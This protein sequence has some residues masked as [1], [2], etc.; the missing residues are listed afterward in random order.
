MRKA[1]HPAAAFALLGVG[2]GALVCF[3]TEL[4]YIRDAFEGAAAR[5]NTIFKFYYQVWLIWGTLAGYALWW[6]IAGRRTEDGRTD[7]QAQSVVGGRWSVVDRV[8]S[9]ACVALTA[10]LFVGALVYPWLT[11]G[12]ALREQP[13]IGL[14][15]KTP[16]Q[17]SAGGAAGIAWLRANTNGAEIVLESVGGDY[18][19]PPGGPGGAG[20]SAST[21]LATVLGWPG[22]ED[23]WRGGDPKAQAQIAPR[24][25]DVET[26]Y[27]STDVEQVRGLLDK[28]N[29]AFVYIGE[30]ER[31]RYGQT[32]LDKF[33]QLGDKVFAQD[34]VAIYK[35][36]QP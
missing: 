13:A 35:I 6:L 10:A 12:K 1:E 28:Y 23:Q 29:V 21:G 27:S 14:D 4:V 19:G 3:G 25:A 2:L 34:E 11:V 15:G 36:K 5:M 9:V 17:Q 7:M 8:W 18:D 30:A 26:I 22:H 32:S 24:K 16:R 31:R 33:T 20:V